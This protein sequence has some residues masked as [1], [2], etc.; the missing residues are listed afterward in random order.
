VRVPNHT[1]E[2]CSPRIRAT[3]VHTLAWATRPWPSLS[4]SSGLRHGAGIV[5]CER[6]SN[7][8][9]DGS[10]P[11]YLFKQLGRPGCCPGRRARNVM[12]CTRQPARMAHGNRWI[13]RL[14]LRTTKP[15]SN[16]ST[17]APVWV[18]TACPGEMRMLGGASSPHKAAEGCRSPQPDGHWTALEPREASRGAC[19]PARLW[20]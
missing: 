1:S 16:C 19:A 3:C 14:S 5:R 6:G 17:G 7:R 15:L 10:L 11:Y 18:A 4:A 12:F 2:A 13:P 20:L 9:S 8:E